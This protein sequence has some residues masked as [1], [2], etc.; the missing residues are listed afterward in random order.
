MLQRTV[1]GLRGKLIA[2][3]IGMPKMIMMKCGDDHLRASAAP[4]AGSERCTLKKPE[5]APPNMLKSR[6]L[7][8]VEHLRL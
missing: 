4:M 1:E 7:A 5:I 3:M 6:P 2:I 8:G